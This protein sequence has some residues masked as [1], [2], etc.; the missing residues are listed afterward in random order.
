VQAAIVATTLLPQHQHQQQQQQQN[1]AA[2]A[3]THKRSTWGSMSVEYTYTRCCCRSSLQSKGCVVALVV[4]RVATYTAAIPAT[5]AT[6]T[7]TAA[8]RRQL[9]PT[10]CNWLSSQSTTGRLTVPVYSG[11]KCLLS[12]S[13]CM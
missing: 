3:A 4:A 10:L 5:P 6:A 8:T 9:R 7:A 1:A 11:E 12:V 2:A 13:L